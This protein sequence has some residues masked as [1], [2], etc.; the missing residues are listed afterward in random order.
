MLVWLSIAALVSVAAIIVIARDR[1]VHLQ[2]LLAGGAV[3]PG[4]AIAEAVA[5]LLVALETAL[6]VQPDRVRDQ[7]T[8][9]LLRLAFGVA[10]L[11]CRAHRKEST[12]LVAFDDDGELE[13][14]HGWILRQE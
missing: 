11:E 12:V 5:L 6:E 2:S 4:C 1:I 14:A 9:F 13:V 7:L 10:T 3:M 8:R